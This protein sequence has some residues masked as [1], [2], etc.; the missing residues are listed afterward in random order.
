MLQ[1]ILNKIK[2]YVHDRSKYCFVY[3]LTN[4]HLD[5]PGGDEILGIAD[6]FGMCNK[7]ANAGL[8]RMLTNGR[9]TTDDESDDFTIKV[10]AHEVG[11]L[12]GAGHPTETRKP[13]KKGTIMTSDIDV[14]LNF[15]T[16]NLKTMR[17]HLKRVYLSEHRFMPQGHC[18][19]YKDGTKPS[20][21]NYKIRSDYM[22]YF[23]SQNPCK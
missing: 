10:M 20:H 21:T 15:T 8:S 13:G 22:G 14:H 12:F 19:K 18:L 1:F 3:M 5:Y 11:H 16:P 6:R 17:A 23:S 4:R 7:Y 9:G 2:E